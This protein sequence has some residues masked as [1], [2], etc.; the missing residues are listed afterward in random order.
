[1]RRNGSYLIIFGICICD[2]FNIERYSITNRSDV[3][4]PIQL[5]QRKIGVRFN[6]LVVMWYQLM[7]RT[8]FNTFRI[9]STFFASCTGFSVEKRL[10]STRVT[11]NTRDTKWAEAN[12]RKLKNVNRFYHA[13]RRKCW[14][15]WDPKT[16]GRPVISCEEEH[17][18]YRL[19]KVDRDHEFHMILLK[20]LITAKIDKLCNR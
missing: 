9:S 19:N 4:H 6:N 5:F 17:R 3:F 16:S 1:M 7:L 2:H 10:A 12:I 11:G 8:L 15:S 20:V 14:K 18:K 13:Y